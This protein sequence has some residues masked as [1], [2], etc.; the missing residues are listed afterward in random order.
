MEG[1]LDEMADRGAAGCIGTQS[2][3]S[4][5]G[6]GLSSR[7][8]LESHEVGGVDWLARDTVSCVLEATSTVEVSLLPSG[9]EPNRAGLESSSK[10]ISSAAC[11]KCFVR[12]SSFFP[13]LSPRTSRSN[14]SS[15]G[16]AGREWAWIGS[17]RSILSRPLSRDALVVIATPTC[18]LQSPLS[19]LFKREFAI[20]VWSS[21]VQPLYCCGYQRPI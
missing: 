2:G 14:T 20:L 1:G 17:I 19:Y 6:G 10:P 4:F 21:V 9:H 5:G 8:S 11:L 12:S 13:S 18:W 16:V 7:L 3:R 15:S